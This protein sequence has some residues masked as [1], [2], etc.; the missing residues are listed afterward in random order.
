MSSGCEKALS[1]VAYEICED[2]AK[3]GIKYAEVRY[4]PQLFA[5]SEE[6]PV[7]AMEKG[8]FTPR[9]VVKTV[10]EALARGKK[11]FGVTVNSILCIMTHS[12]GT[13]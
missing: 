10:N 7:Y 2:F 5:N 13:P 1:R 12:P 8:N 3:H 11:D 4:C 9:D 6:K